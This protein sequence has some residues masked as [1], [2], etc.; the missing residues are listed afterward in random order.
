MNYEVKTGA[1]A[2][3]LSVQTA[4]A[5]LVGWGLTFGGM[6]TVAIVL[7]ASAVGSV[8]RPVLGYLMRFLPKP[9]SEGG[10]S[11]LM[12]VVLLAVLAV[13]LI[14]LLGPVTIGR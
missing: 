6:D 5:A 12:I 3:W 4:I 8:A 13:C 1:E 10:E 14:W 7:V 2:I 11:T 9:P